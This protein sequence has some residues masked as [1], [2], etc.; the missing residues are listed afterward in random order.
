MNGNVLSRVTPRN[1][2]L[3]SCFNLDKDKRGDKNRE[4]DKDIVDSTFIR[5]NPDTGD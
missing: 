5:T 4:E 1:F 2:G 3:G